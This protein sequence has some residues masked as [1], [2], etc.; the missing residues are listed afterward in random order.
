MKTTKKMLLLAMLP[1]L[2]TSCELLEEEPQEE[3]KVDN[4]TY[5]YSYTCPTGRK[6][7]IQIPNRLSASCKANWE[8]FARTY[9]C[10]DADNFAE[11]NRRK[12]QCP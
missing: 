8:Y 4:S 12:A 6:N 9:G 2:A 3:K 11:A 1:V 5:T 10:N 7:T